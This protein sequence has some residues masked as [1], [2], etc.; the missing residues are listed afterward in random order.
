[1]RKTVNTSRLADENIYSIT[2]RILRTIAVIAILFGFCVTGYSLYDDFMID[3]EAN[4]D[5]LL[6]Y[7]PGYE[8]AVPDRKIVGTMAAWLTIPDTSIDYPVMKGTTNDEYLDKDPYGDYSFAGSIFLDSRNDPDFKDDYSLIYGHHMAGENMFGPL[9]NYMEKPFFEA[10][11]KAD[12]IIDGIDYK[13]TFF[14]VLK[15]NAAQPVIFSPTEYGKD[16]VLSF[17]K[18][19]AV[20][21]DTN[22]AENGKEKRIA[23]LSTCQYPDIM[24][25]TVVAGYLDDFGAPVEDREGSETEG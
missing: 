19:N 1:M 10:H 23:A 8:T 14:A 7:K 3:R 6:Q 18:E 24:D 9:T 12:L 13:V 21:L 15:V 25:R 16:E 20:I 11:R 2:N 22:L 4:D 5:S 17:M